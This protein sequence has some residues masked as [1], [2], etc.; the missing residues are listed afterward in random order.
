[1]D[2]LSINIALVSAVAGLLQIILFFKVWGMCNDV[3]AIRKAQ[4][5]E[6][7]TT[8]MSNKNNDG[9][10]GMLV[11]SIAIIVIIVVFFVM[12]IV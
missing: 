11:R 5:P 4:I 7:P 12:Q 6:V 10:W 2:T 8:D 3:R 9:G 1:M